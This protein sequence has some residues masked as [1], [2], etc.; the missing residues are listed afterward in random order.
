ML[1]PGII[2]VVFGLIITGLGGF[3]IRAHYTQPQPYEIV[4]NDTRYTFW[5]NY[6]RPWR[7]DYATRQEAAEARDKKR[8]E[9]ERD[10]TFRKC[11]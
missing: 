8:A 2:I 5:T 6:N 4:C 10:E 11:R 9:D 1:A 3:V 7:T